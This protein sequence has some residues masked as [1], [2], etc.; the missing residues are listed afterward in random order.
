MKLLCLEDERKEGGMDS[1]ESEVVFGR[2]G[3]EDHGLNGP[4][5]EFAS[6]G[7]FPS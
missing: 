3:L 4:F 1:R 7:R 5:P 2:V 6:M